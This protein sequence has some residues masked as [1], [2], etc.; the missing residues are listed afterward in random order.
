MSAIKNIIAEE[1]Q[2]SICSIRYLHDPLVLS[3]THLSQKPLPF[4][5]PQTAMTNLQS[6]QFVTFNALGGAL[7]YYSSIPAVYESK[8]WRDAMEASRTCLY[9]LSKDKSVADSPIRGGVTLSKLAK[10]ELGS[11]F[12]HRAV[13]GAAY[14]Y[15]FCISPRRLEI[16]AVLNVIL[17]VFD[18]M[19]IIYHTC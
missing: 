16:I 12:K 15:P 3:S 7:P 14:M 2:A 9:L 6:A 17:F 19:R 8:F 1:D 13:R 10:K 18:G 4:P 5:R 11:G